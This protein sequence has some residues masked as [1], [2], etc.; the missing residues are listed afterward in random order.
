MHAL[1]AL[2]SC[3]TYA[4]LLND[5]AVIMAEHYIHNTCLMISSMIHELINAAHCMITNYKTHYGTTAD[6]K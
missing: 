1:S 4:L 6:D 5:Y 3:K 2:L